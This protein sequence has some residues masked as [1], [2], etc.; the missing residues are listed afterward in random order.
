MEAEVVSGVEGQSVCRACL[1]P[2]SD[3]CDLFDSGHKLARLLMNC[4]DVKVFRDDGLPSQMCKQCVVLAT[5]AFDFKHKCE[6][7][8]S[9]LRSYL[10]TIDAVDIKHEQDILSNE[11]ASAESTNDNNGICI[12]ILCKEKH[13]TMES[14]LEH[15]IQSHTTGA[16]IETE[17]FSC[18]LC[19]RQYSSE[20]DVKKH[21]VS[22]KKFLVDNK[23]N[24]CPICREEFPRHDILLRH[25]GY[26]IEDSFF[27]CTICNCFFTTNLHLKR[28]VKR[29][30]ESDDYKMSKSII[31]ADINDYG[32]LP[33]K[34]EPDHI[35]DNTIIKCEEKDADSVDNDLVLGSDD[36]ISNITDS[37]LNSEYMKNSPEN[38]Y[39]MTNSDYEDKTEF[40]NFIDA[41]EE[42]ETLKIPKKKKKFKGMKIKFKK[43]NKNMC[44]ND[45]LKSQQVL[46]TE[47]MSNNKK[48]QTGERSF[49]CSICGKGYFKQNHL[50]KHMENHSNEQVKKQLHVCTICGKVVHHSNHL[51]VHM[52]THKD[53][54]GQPLAPQKTDPNKKLILC[55]MCGKS[56]SS[57][58]NLAVHM[59]RHLGVMTCICKICGKGYPRTTDLTL[60]MRQH[61]GERP[62]VCTHCNKG[63]ARSDK[64]AIHMRIHTGE[65][66]YSCQICGRS[67]AQS[68]DLTA[69]K[70]RNSCNV[71]QNSSNS[72]SSDLSITNAS[73]LSGEN[74]LM[75]LAQNRTAD[76]LPVDSST[77][78]K[79]SV[80][81]VQ[82]QT[83]DASKTRRIGNSNQHQ[84]MM[85]VTP[86]GL[87]TLTGEEEDLIASVHTRALDLAT[88]ANNLLVASAN[89]PNNRVIEFFNAESMAARSVS[90]LV[91]QNLIVPDI[92]T[93]RAIELAN[94][95]HS[96]LAA[97]QRGEYAD[98][99]TA[100]LLQ[101]LSNV[102]SAHFD[103][104]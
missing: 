67:F 4:C 46:R 82:S 57:R 59:R 27:E 99:T 9:K 29:R 10:I 11:T 84:K 100:T 40:S 68:N 87:D 7:A 17:K 52:R 76:M 33:I 66:P 60:H 16:K 50:D 88:A 62:F 38:D 56:C 1:S 104:R 23:S 49:L 101:N 37:H 78:S 28:H 96:M 103:T 47:N 64:L 75:F 94:A 85:G 58:S 51:L 72:H 89:T 92:L 102:Q 35:F 53:R 14:L 54:N 20:F 12:C 31:T 95:N 34:L 91:R 43:K 79:L 71:N 5:S 93:T 32:N 45:S 22:H 77:Y 21:Q 97:H 2:A 26:H 74:Q 3:M 86:S 19:K 25:M 63:F 8:D 18:E 6:R 48:R 42:I 73:T 15:V 65:K 81:N 30:H 41:N 61:T 13:E 90:D 69:H 55:S 39:D 98:Y 80:K 83:V 70:K 44:D 24:T 36:F